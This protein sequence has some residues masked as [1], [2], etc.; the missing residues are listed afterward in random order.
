MHSS[1][2]AESSQAN[3][4]VS[5]CNASF[6]TTMDFIGPGSPNPNVSAIKN[7]LNNFGP[8]V[9]FAWQVP[10]FG[11]GKTSVRGGFQVTYWRRRPQHVNDRKRDVCGS[12]V[13]SG[14][15]QYPERCDRAVLPDLYNCSAHDCRHSAN[16]ASCADQP[17]CARWNT[18]HLHSNATAITGYGPEYATPYIENFTLSVTRNINRKFTMDLRYVGTISKKQEA[19][20][21]VNLS[22]IYNNKEFVDA[23]ASAACR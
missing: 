20:T 11:E 4:P 22:N 14:Q 16:R 19:D 8:A 3:L 21:N 10:W 13:G 7:D 6:M 9:G 5:S 12:G 23:L 1:A 2:R 18:A 17:C 15:F